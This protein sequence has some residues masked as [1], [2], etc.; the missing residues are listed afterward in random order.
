M[1]KSDKAA[2]LGELPFTEGR[3]YDIPAGDGF[4]IQ[5]SDKELTHFLH[6]ERPPGEWKVGS[7]FSVADSGDFY[8][9]KLNDPTIII[10]T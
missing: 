10:I 9:I 2:T 4:N 3:E 5:P 7:E 1:R 8:L 6:F